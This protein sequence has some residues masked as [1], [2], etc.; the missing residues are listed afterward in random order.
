MG[1][2]PPRGAAVRAQPVDEDLC[3]GSEEDGA[4]CARVA[5]R[6]ESSVGWFDPVWC[7]MH[8][9]GRTTEPYERAPVRVAY[10]D[11]RIGAYEASFYAADD[12]HAER[13]ARRL[14]TLVF[15]R[16]V[17]STRP[18]CMAR[19]WSTG[20]N[21]VFALYRRRVSSAGVI[22]VEGSGRYVFDETFAFEVPS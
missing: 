6:I 19:A 22:A 8:A 7:D 21:V 2:R 15:P 4:P 16:Y 3:M 12:A 17:A 18:G 14:R 11:V 9:K 20:P 5:T 13:V 1:S 10:Y